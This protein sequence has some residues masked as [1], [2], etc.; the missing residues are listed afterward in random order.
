MHTDWMA[1][2]KHRKTQ[3]GSVFIRVYL[4][5]S[6]LCVSVTPVAAQWT[7]WR[8]PNGL[9]VSPE[10]DLPTTWSPA[11]PTKPAVNIRWKTEIPG[12]G[13]SSPVVWGN[14]IFLTT[15]IKGVEVPGKTAPVHLDFSRQPGY[16]HP[17]STD[18]NFKHALQV[19]AVDAKSGKILWQKT[20][21]DGEMWD[22]R[23]RKN[24]FASSTM[25]V[26]EE[27]AYAFFESAGLYAYRHD[28]TLAWKKSLGG[29]IKAGL[30]P[31]TSPIIYKE[32]IIL[33]C[34]QEMGDGSF[35][36]ALDRK[37]GEEV[38][39][40]TRTNRRSWATPLVVHA[41]ERDELIASGAESVIAYDPATG[42]E[43]WR[44]DGTRSHPIPSPVATKGLV[45]LTAG[46]QAKVVMA[47]RPGANGDQKD[48]IVWRY[49]K[50]AAYV[51][52]PI[53]LGDYLYLV[54]DAGLMTCIDAVT[55]ER[56]YE[57]GRPPVPATF[58]AS[59]VAF[60]GKILLTSED[61][62]SFLIKA[63]PVHEVLATGSVG[64]PVYAS[65]AI[66]NSTIYIRGDAHL[67]AITNTGKQP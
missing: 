41:G 50:G 32:L 7:Q 11:T 57:G 19:I 5:L 8:G 44:S 45:F 64:E 2:D 62:D 18:V 23:H 30:G 56:R 36:V 46:S 12:R 15:S 34:D 38:W 13:H 66:A 67:F 28:G 17:D 26:D 54:T 55:G 39:R 53:A 10:K 16:V 58:F 35:I 27:R 9:G 49:N 60:D 63:G 43:L 65:P 25:A 33:Q 37:T 51:P 61:G 1:T 52:S 6:L 3:N 22:D 4:W 59:P 42:K 47:M 21:Y 20:A 48:A 24:T 14:R 31:G 29:I 40:A